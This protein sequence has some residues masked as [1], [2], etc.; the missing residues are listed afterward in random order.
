MNSKP[1]LDSGSLK[2]QRLVP[3]TKDQSPAGSMAA[4]GSAATTSSVAT[5]T[6]KEHKSARPERGGQ[7]TLI[8]AIRQGIWEEME[9]DP[10]VFVIGE[11]VGAYGGAFKVTD[12]LIDEF[13]AG[14]VIDTP[15]SEAAIVG[16]ACGAGL[17]GTKAG[18]EVRVLG[19]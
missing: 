16:A 7:A 3:K 17:M 10:T 13:G 12:G 1:T 2:I 8:E 18:S 15:I 5:A 11:D 6:K 9:R 14:R 19:F 4:A